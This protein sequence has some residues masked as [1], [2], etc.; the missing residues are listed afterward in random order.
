[1]R[2]T[3][4]G[5]PPSCARPGPRAQD[6]SGREALT[7]R[8]ARACGAETPTPGSR[9]P[10]SPPRRHAA[11]RAAAR[12]PRGPVGPAGPAGRDGIR[13]RWP[14]SSSWSRS[15]PSASASGRCS[16]GPCTARTG[17]ATPWRRCAGRASTSPTSSASTRDPS[18]AGVEELV[19][20]Q[21]PG[22]DARPGRRPGGCEVRR[23][24]DGRRR[25]RG[26]R[27]APTAARSASPTSAVPVSTSDDRGAGP[28]PTAPASAATART[29]LVGRDVVLD[30]LDAVLRDAAAGRGRV[31]VVSGEPG[32]GKTR[33]HR[34]RWP[35]GAPR[36]GFA[37]GTGG[38][39]TEAEPAAVGV[40]AAPSRTRSAAPQV[41]DRV[42]RR[43]RRR[44]RRA[45]GRPTPSPRPCG[46]GADGVAPRRRALGRR[47][48]PA[49][50]PTGGRPAR[51]GCRSSCSS[52]ACGPP[53][54]TTDPRSS[55]PCRRWRGSTRCGWSSRPRRRR[56]RRV[57]RGP[58]RCRGGSRGRRRRSSSGPT[59][60][61]FYVDRAGAAAGRRGRA[62][63]ARRPGLARGA[64]RR[65]R[66]RTPATGRALGPATSQVLRDGGRGW[67]LVRPG[68]RR[69]AAGGGRGRRR[70]RPWSRRSCSGSSR[71]A[72]SP[73]A[74]GSPTRWSVT[75]STRWCP[76]RPGPGARRRGA[77][78]RGPLRRD[79]SRDTSAELAE[80]YR[81]AGPAHARSGWVFA[82]R[83]ATA[84]A[85]AVG[86]TT[87]RCGSPLGAPSCRSGPGRD[88]RPSARPTCVGQA[89]RCGPR[90]S[91]STAWPPVAAAG[92]RPWPGRRRGGRP[93]PADHHRADR[94]GVA[95]DQ[96]RST[97]TPSGCGARPRPAAAGEAVPRAVLQAAWPSS[98]STSP[99]AATGRR[100][101]PMTR[102]RRPAV[103]DATRPGARRHPGLAD[104]GDA[105]PDLLHHRARAGRRA[106]RASR[107]T[108][109][110][111][112]SCWPAPRGP[113][114]PT[115]S[116]WTGSSCSRDLDRAEGW[117][118][119]TAAAERR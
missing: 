4:G 103:R 77:R 35:A 25:G 36:W 116:T 53:R 21:D 97:T 82:R 73:A 98:S 78:A 50:A 84:A 67:S 5:S 15:T 85:G 111:T 104:A 63:L 22:L 75:R 69:W 2:S 39:D 23:V 119:S 68:R 113:G 9:A 91:R 7:H 41:L 30:E 81:S 28:A 48:Q 1:M 109:A 19:L 108:R 79:G 14:S 38:W 31:V 61:R 37:V 46:P 55:R 58:R 8:G 44:V 87:R 20:R 72:R 57:G 95:R 118:G 76:R 106:G 26:C 52:P 112:P 65:A 29:T 115:G 16:R 45:S 24:A 59:A 70:R 27:A 114:G 51:H 93:L 94:L 86:R 71:L 6:P 11:G 100:R 17:R 90:P 102:R 34:G 49:P 107:R 12:R 40:D 33:V 64:G 117:P 83:A 101:W 74:T 56:R 99:G 32:I 92:S 80:H 47:R 62:R 10:R 89:G 43:G 88:R 42:G 3:R 60:T 13:R 54:P 105:R 96:G 18:C 110:R 66:R